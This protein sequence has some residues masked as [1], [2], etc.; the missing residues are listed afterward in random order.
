MQTFQTLTRDTSDGGSLQGYFTATRREIEEVFGNPT[1]ACSDT[2]E[3]VTVEWVIKFEDGTY[4]SIYDY[5][6][7]EEGT[8][9]L[10]EEYEWHIGGAS[11][12]SAE[13]VSEA[14]RKEISDFDMSGPNFRKK[15]YG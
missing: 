13:L 12:R 2:W 14:M 4:A 5:K 9:A 10:D 1:I 7:Y 8:P 6:R 3:K 11:F 15:I